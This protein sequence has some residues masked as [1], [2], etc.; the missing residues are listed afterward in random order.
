MREG[1]VVVNEVSKVHCDDP[2]EDD[3][4][5]SFPDSLLWIPLHLTG[6]FSYF[7][8]RKPE[9]KEL[10]ECKKLFLAPDA[11]NWN[12]YCKSFAW[13]EQSMLNFRGEISEKFRWLKD[14]QIFES[15][16]DGASHEIA[17]VTAEEWNQQVDAN[18]S[19]AFACC[20]HENNSGDSFAP[21]INTRA[22]L[23]KLSS[24]IRSCNCTSS[25][26]ADDLFDIGAP[27]TT[28]WD[29]F[30]ESL[31]AMLAPAQISFVKAQMASAEATRPKGVSASLL[32]KLWM[33]K[34]LLAEG[35]LEQNTQ[36][37]RQSADNSM[38]RQ[39]T[40]NDRMLQYKRLQSVFYT[41]T[42]FALKHKSKRQYT[43]CQVFV[44]DKGFVMSYLMKSQ[45][46]FQTALHW[47]CKEVGVPVSLVVDTLRTQTSH[48]V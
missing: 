2:T 45:E 1:S 23:S 33:V 39:Y 31:E 22:E 29:D 16:D 36:L 4:W 10:F 37:C 35:A 3:H 14:P 15:E 43:C 12:P 40:T 21:A 47:F 18:M 32:S 6:I 20:N 11:S 30:E 17:K 13:N 5:I 41:D 19:S 7:P 24:S 42:M 46:E 38:S 44:S 48:E 28:D 9:Q 8:T 25:S 26:K 27:I 34:E